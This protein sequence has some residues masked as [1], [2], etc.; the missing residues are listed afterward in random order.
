MPFKKKKNK[1]DI[2]ITRVQNDSDIQKIRKKLMKIK[3]GSIHEGKVERKLKKTPEHY[4]FEDLDII[5]D[6]LEDK[7]Q[8]IKRTG[9]VSRA[10]EEGL[11]IRRKQVLRLLLR[12]VPKPTIRDYLG[13]SN[14][15]MYRDIE[16][17]N[18]TMREEVQNFDIPLFVG[19][20]LAFYDE[21]RNVALRMASDKKNVK[22]IRGI[23]MSLQTALKAEADKH[24]YLR[25]T[26]LYGIA[27][28]TQALYRDVAGVDSGEHYDDGEDFTKFINSYLTLENKRTPPKQV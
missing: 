17:L 20:T 28:K 11:E 4:D 22:D 6:G 8:K 2:S 24:Q 18:S 12:G 1:D 27:E 5:V 9:E 15:T 23:N 21:V 13:I 25:L 3:P 16:A 19:Y 14:A 10:D 7:D 26:G